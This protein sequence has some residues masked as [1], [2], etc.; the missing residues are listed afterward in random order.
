MSHRIIRRREVEAKTGLKRSAIYA[1]IAE[2]KFPKQVSLGP[3]S[4]GWV[5][6][7]VDAWLSSAAVVT[8][9]TLRKHFFSFADGARARVGV[10]PLRQSRHGSF[11]G[12]S[13]RVDIGPAATATQRP[14]S[15]N[16]QESGLSLQRSAATK[17]L[18]DADVEPL[19]GGYRGIICAALTCSL[20]QK[21]Y[22]RRFQSRSTN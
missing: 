17:T 14:A 18:E 15:K 12:L 19:C 3:G 5:E 10:K 6:Q 11:R 2:G 1:S 7:E 20:S 16:L 4:V 22:S 8:V 21:P 13:T 9:P